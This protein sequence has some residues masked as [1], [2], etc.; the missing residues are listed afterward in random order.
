MMKIVFSFLCGVL[1]FTS[2]QNGQ[3]NELGKDQVFQKTFQNIRLGD[4]VPL[5]LQISVRW[6]VQN[7]SKFL[8]QFPNPGAYDSLILEP[9]EREL[10]NDIANDYMSVDSVFTIQRTFFIQ[11]IKKELKGNLGEDGIAIKEIIV[12]DIIFPSTF[13]TA[14]E[15]VSLKE[16]QLDA[17]RLEKMSDLEKAKANEETA[18]ANGKVKIEEARAEGEIARMNAQ[19]EQQKRRVQLEEAETEIKVMEAKAKS[20]VNQLKLMEAAKLENER[21]AYAL[22]YTRDTA[23]ARIYTKNPVYARYLINKELA[24]K[25]QVAIIP[26]HTEVNSLLE[27]INLNGQKK[28]KDNEPIEEEF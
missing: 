9:R 20:E 6:N 7:S 15:Q 12:S 22:Y 17:I 19:I 10:L 25:V 11:D 23:L 28:S 18:K 16:R 14:M 2:C 24:S 27:G 3:T 1:L 4:G 13:T 26:P 8:S 5:S 21:N